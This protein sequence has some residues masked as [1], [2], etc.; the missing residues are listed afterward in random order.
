MMKR[1][2]VFDEIRFKA[3]QE[4]LSGLKAGFLAR[5]YNV[6]PKTIHN[7]VKEYREQ[8]GD[9]ILQSVDTRIS[10]SKRLQELEERYAM[11]MKV[12]GEKELEIEI[13]RELAKKANP[14]Y[15]IKLK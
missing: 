15:Q 8:Y 14:A 5:K 3:A 11:A 13:L 2:S 4:A 7:W 1:N 6:S 10:E 12:L 9:A